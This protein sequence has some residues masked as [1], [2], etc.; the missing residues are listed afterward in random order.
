M[1]VRLESTQGLGKLAEVWV[2]EQLLGVCDNISLGDSRQRPG[3]LEG[4]QFRYVSDE[5]IQWAD[6][7]AGNRARKKML[8]HVR[9]W[10]YLGYGQVAS[11]MPTIIDFGTLIMTD[12]NWT[13]DD[14]LVNKYVLV[15]IDRL[16]LIPS[17]KSDWPPGLE[18]LPP[19]VVPRLDEG[20]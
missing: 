2:D 15:Q 14:S 17:S 13:T 7:L 19:R 8:Q 6:A 4:V 3:V 12:P 1:E 9:G 16:E 18:P 10:T 5:P 20:E 11:I